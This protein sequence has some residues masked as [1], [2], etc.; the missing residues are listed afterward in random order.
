MDTVIILQILTILISLIKP[1]AMYWIQAKYNAA[2]PHN[3]IVER[4][5]ITNEENNKNDKNNKI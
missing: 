5:F 3:A 1:V 4:T 2:A